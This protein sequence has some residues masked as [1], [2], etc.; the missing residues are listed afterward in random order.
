MTTKSRL[1][2]Y[3]RTARGAEAMRFLETVERAETFL[4]GLRRPAAV[5]RVLDGREVG[6]VSELGGVPDD[7]RFRWIWWLEQDA[8]GQ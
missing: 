8:C 1:V 2:V 3:Y 4:R 5:K 6:G 7:R